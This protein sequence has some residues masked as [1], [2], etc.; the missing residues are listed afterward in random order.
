MTSIDLAVVTNRTL[1]TIIPARELVLNDYQN[2][3]NNYI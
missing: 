2:L 1:E 3:P